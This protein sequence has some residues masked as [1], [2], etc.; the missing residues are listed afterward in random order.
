[1]PRS[2]HQ[3]EK[4]SHVALFVNRKASGYQAKQIDQLTSAVKERGGY[5]TTFEPE[6]AMSLYKQALAIV[7]PHKDSSELAPVVAKRGE[8]TALIACGGDG[9]FNLVARAAMESE[10]PVG[11]LP[12]GRFNNIARY[13]YQAVEP[14]VAIARILKGDYKKIDAGMAAD[15]PFFNAIGIGFLPELA[16][17]LKSIRSPRFGFGWSQLGAK[18][19]SAVTVEKLVA[20]IDAFRFEISPVMMNIHLLPYAVGLPFASAALVDDGQAEVIFDQ[21]GQLGEFSSITRAIQKGKFLYGTDVRMYRGKTINLQPIKDK[22]MY[23]D[24][25]LI[26]LPTTVLAVKIGD[27]QV[28]VFC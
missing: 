6:S 3:K 4:Q 11:I 18:A 24:G 22:V 8:F 28:K 26:T 9:T 13:L 27:K 12:M 25:E 15:Q 16:D 17:N 19:A 1:M 5:Y 14:K 20:K 2:R 10:L 21:G 7:Q 23:L